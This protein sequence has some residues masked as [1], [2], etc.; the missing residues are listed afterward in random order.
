[1]S[2]GITVAVAGNS[3]INRR[4]SVHTEDRFL[5][6]IKII[7]EADVGYTHFETVIH[8][9]DGPEVYPAAEPAATP[10]R[11]PRFVAE[12]IKWAGFNLVSL[13]HNHVLDYSYGG[14]FSTWEAL[15]ASGL[16]H[17]GT[18]R[19][20]GEARAPAYLD[21]ARG[22]VALV[23]MCATFPS[24]S[25]A[26]EARRDMKG[27]PGINPLRFY[28]VADAGT[29][30]V[31]KQLAIKSAWQI[32]KAGKVWLFNPTGL[33]G[34]LYKFVEGDQPGISTAVEEEDAE[35]NLR[36]IRDAVRQADYVLAQLHFHEFHPDQGF[37]VPPHFVPPFARACLDAG[38]HMFLGQGHITP[39]GI[40]IYNGKPVFYDPGTFIG[41][42]NTVTRLPSDFYFRPGHSAEMRRWEATT[43][44]ALDARE[45]LP[46][47]HP[48]ASSSSAPVEGSILARCSLG[49]NGKL[50][51]LKLY[52][53][54]VARA[55]RPASGL[56][57]LAA[58]EHAAKIIAY[59][60][61][62]SAPFGTKIDYRDGAGFV[63]L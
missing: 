10:M 20:L 58:G 39:R 8:D 63:A 54:T 26:G 42:T 23:S 22:R 16:V 47:L 6:M 3:I 17:A 32:S 45:G 46:R 44:D 43:A 61:E 15:N 56:P 12:E 52:P 13:A 14:L 40:E 38:A 48:P 25:R 41:M 7:R 1:M 21:T 60:G 59:I 29:M 37:H 33:A 19:N 28:T 18:G 11:S 5:S 55:P 2:T 30:E 4:I 62:L 31:I 34:T 53:V 9:Y 36:S 50:A 49:G 51:E 24:W 27:R 57:M 35:A